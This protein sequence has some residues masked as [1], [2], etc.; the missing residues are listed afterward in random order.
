M[1][2]ML[3]KYEKVKK[4]LAVV[5]TFES[6]MYYEFKTCEGTASFHLNIML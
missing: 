5:K 4:K 6:T 3:P 2:G 1:Q